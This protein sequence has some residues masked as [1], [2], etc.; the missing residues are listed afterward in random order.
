MP[1]GV[2]APLTWRSLLALGV[3]GGLIPCPSALLVMLAAITLDR[4][5]FGLVLVTAFSV[6]LAGVLMA[7]GLLMVYGGKAIQRS[8]AFARVS[9]LLEGRQWALKALPVIAPVGVIIAG[10][11]ITYD[12]LTRPGLFG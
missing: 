5:V 2:D 11:I 7:V 9:S 12:A 1:P 10:G 6:G 8:N 3:S 4:V